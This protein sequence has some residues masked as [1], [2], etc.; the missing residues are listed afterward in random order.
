MGFPRLFPAPRHVEM[1][2]EGVAGD[3]APAWH[4]DA[5]LPAEGFTIRVGDGAIRVAHADDAGRRH[6]GDVLAQLRRHHR[7]RLPGLVIRDWPDFPVRGYL[8]DVSRDRVPTRAT[9]ARLVDLLGRCR[10]N[11]LQLY[12]EHAFAYRDHEIVWR[13]ASPLTPEDLRWLDARC[14][15]RGIE[16]AANQNGFGH[17]ERWLRHDR[18]RPLAECPDGW[19]TSFGAAMPPA[20]LAPSDD[21]LAFVLALYRELA[22]CVESRRINV[23]CD[24]TFEL[25]RGR[26]RAAVERYGRGRVYLDF[27]RRQIDALQADGHEVLFWADVLRRH[28]E[29]LP[30]L[31]AT[32]AVALCWHYEAPR[33]TSDLPPWVDDVMAEFGMRPDDLRGFAAQVPPFAAHGVPFWVC[34]GT[35][36]WNSLLGRLPNARANVDDAANVGRAHGAGGLLVTD[37]GD[38]G[39]HQPL[40]VSVPAVVYAAAQAWCHESKRDVALADVVDEFVFDDE[41]GELGRALEVAGSVYDRTG[42]VPMNGS[43]LHQQLLTGGLGQLGK[44]L[45]AADAD[46]VRRTL[47]ALEE[48]RCGVER[49]RPR[50]EDG[51]TVRRELLCAIRLAR[52]GAWRIA[53]GAGLPAPDVAVL[54]RDLDEAIDE[55]RACW[56][57]RSREGGLA[58]SVARLEATRRE[59]D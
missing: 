50:C 27:L 31:P 3:V 1:Q 16:L 4:R 23:G 9:L 44:L 48:A 45:G 5:G 12:V 21:A 6:A 52:H 53:R 56:R 24:E 17:M 20:V 13:D 22:A 38:N 49:S 37:W 14:R 59:Y 51:S 35:S 10:L 39:H 25:G 29:L 30:E 32:D 19:T 26:H 15:A 8:L 34:P 42:L 2:G 7:E 43:P 18:Y 57:L 46:G 33:A 58:D 47:D 36:T 28:P 40:A 55:Q 54:R 41:A 11:H